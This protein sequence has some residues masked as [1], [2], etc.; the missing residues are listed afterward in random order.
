MID[1]FGSA[2]QPEHWLP[3]LVTME[4]VAACC[5]TEPGCESDAAALVT[6]ARREGDQLVL[7]GTKGFKSG[8]GL[9]DYG[10]EKIEGGLHVHQILE[11][12]NEIMRLI[13]A[14]SMTGS[15]S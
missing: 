14:R 13:I 10:I 15:R 1:R 7:D 12:T 3:G 4:P 6:S 2:E 9:A 8:A 5:L 11:G